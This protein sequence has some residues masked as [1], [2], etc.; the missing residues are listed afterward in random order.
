MRRAILNKAPE[1]RHTLPIKR[2]EQMR[3]GAL[4]ILALNRQNHQPSRLRVCLPVGN[5]E[6]KDETN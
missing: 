1:E 2:M 5:I 4:L 6:D 3:C